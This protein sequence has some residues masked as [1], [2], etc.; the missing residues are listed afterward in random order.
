MFQFGVCRE[1]LLHNASFQ[2]SELR[3]IYL[4]NTNTSHS[5]TSVTFSFVSFL[6]FKKQT[7]TTDVQAGT[8][9]K[10]KL[11][12]DWTICIHFLNFCWSRVVCWILLVVVVFGFCFVVVLDFLFPT[13]FY[14]PIEAKGILISRKWLCN[15]PGSH[16]LFV[17]Q[18]IFAL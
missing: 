7:Q 15:S 4:L 9:Q 18:L 8:F 12:H 14:N 10:K 17:N 16:H 5:V 11:V 2:N 6:W 3:R 13:F 1:N